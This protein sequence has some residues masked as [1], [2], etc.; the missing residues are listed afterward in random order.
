M[1]TTWTNESKSGAAV[2]AQVLKIDDTYDLLIDSTFKLQ[3]QA[4]STGTVW[5]NQ[6]K[7]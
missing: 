2:T 4:A 5:N 6:S 1:A 7:S 3:I